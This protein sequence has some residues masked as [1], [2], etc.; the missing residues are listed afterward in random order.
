MRSFFVVLMV[1]FSVCVSAQDRHSSRRAVPSASH[2]RA[3]VSDN[4]IKPRVQQ[5]LYVATPEQVTLMI[6]QLNKLSFA[7][8]KVD[9][10]YFCV[11]LLPI[12]AEGIRKLAE[13]M[14]F[15]SAKLDFL[16]E[17]F[18]YCPDTLNYIVV[19]RAFSFSSSAEELRR[20]IEKEYH[21]KYAY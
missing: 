12:P 10:A 19:E 14:S 3:G 4:R 20:H 7:Q 11:K 8:D 17:A 1:V 6:E 9:F 18:K 2:R 13:T 16:K 15:D 21:F 5:P